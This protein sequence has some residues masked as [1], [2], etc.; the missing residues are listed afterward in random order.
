MIVTSIYLSIH[1]TESTIRTRQNL[2]F[3]SVFVCWAFVLLCVYAHESA[4]ILSVLYVPASLLVAYFFSDKRNLL[5]YFFYI[6]ILTFLV[7]LLLT[8]LWTSS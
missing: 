1:G 4:D 5:T 3:L 2:S 6:L 8:R 7:Y